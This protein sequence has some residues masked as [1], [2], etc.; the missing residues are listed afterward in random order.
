MIRRLKSLRVRL[1]L[2]VAAM[3]LFTVILLSALFSRAYTGMILRREREAHA[4]G[5][6]TISRS[7]TPLMESSVSKVRGSIMLDE[8]VAA[9]I[10]APDASARERIRAR[11]RC[12]DYLRGEIA[13]D[14]DGISGILFMRKDGSL[15]GVLP[16]AT[17]FLDDPAENPLPEE[18]RKRI[19]DLP[20]GQTVWAGPVSGTRLY[21]FR[22]DK[23]PERI[24]IAAWKT[25]D[26]AYGECCTMMLT[27]GSVFDRLFAALD[28]GAGTWHVFTADRTEIYHT[29][30]GMCE[31]MDRLI[32][33][34]NSGEIF[35]GEDGRPVCA[36]AMTMD[37]PDWTF[38]REASMEEYERIS[39]GVSGSAAVLTLAVFAAG[40]GF[41]QLWLRKF[42]RQFRALLQGITR[43]GQS[44]SEPAAP[45]IST[46]TEFEIM[47][48]EI[49]RTSLALNGQMET[50][51]KMTAE[52]ERVSTEMNLARNIQAS[53]LP[54]SFPAFP[55]RNEFDLYADMRPAADVGG[56][57]YDFFM[58][59]DNRLALV[60]ADVS[61][62]GVPA[63]LFMMTAKTMLKDYL[64]TGCDPAQALQRMN[65]QL[66]R[67]NPSM[68]F[69]TVWVAVVELST[70]RGLACNA[71]HENPALR[72]A[73]GA[74]E[75]LHYPHNV[76]V[77]GLK[78]ARYRNREF[79][80]QPGDCLFVYTDGVPE[81][82][83][84]AGKMFREDRLAETLNR[85]PD[86]KPEGLVRRVYGEVDR[87]MDGAEQFDDITM[88]CFRY[89][90]TG[91]PEQQGNAAA[92]NREA[93]DS[94]Q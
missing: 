10:K 31:D 19:L 32:R 85:C 46:I 17:L 33:E 91:K 4:V 75:L 81:A 16:E 30:Q 47:Q 68:M 25:V 51:R 69:V 84:P 43:M 24:M 64:L 55:D 37:S 65:G 74:F 21:G 11:I 26:V 77:G 15:F 40:V 66:G 93:K 36:F 71:G 5:F 29:G 1:L 13:G 9:C 35:T 6:E 14:N 53:A 23:T 82:V 45:G 34:S 94:E 20:L 92:E 58:V 73:G 49:N 79:E 88:L 38:V 86:P 50:I 18:M 54:G 42:M 83:S 27:D 22:N 7:F 8:R 2:P 52:K 60:I 78:E 56:D 63:A 12:R 44:G 76:L 57:F 39:R 62:K 41:Y 72:R 61:G 80:L 90:G 3:M 87:F 70:G 89:L 28:D 59:D 67:K 48:R